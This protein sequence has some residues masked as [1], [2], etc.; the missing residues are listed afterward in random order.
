MEAYP[1]GCRLRV[2]QLQPGAKSPQLYEAVEQGPLW[3]R[4][5]CRE[6]CFPRSL[7]IHYSAGRP[8]SLLWIEMAGPGLTGPSTETLYYEPSI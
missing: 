2:Q 1:Q 4:F 7:E 3:I 6:R 8:C 5:A